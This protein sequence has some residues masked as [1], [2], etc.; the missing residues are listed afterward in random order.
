MT[1]YGRSRK[2]CNEAAV[3]ASLGLKDLSVRR[4]LVLPSKHSSTLWSGRHTG[5]FRAKA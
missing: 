4:P 1:L 2:L 3:L 5:M